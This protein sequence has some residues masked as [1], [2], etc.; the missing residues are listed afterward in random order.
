M[1]EGALVH[2]TGDIE[3][4]LFLN[5][6][7]VFKDLRSQINVLASES[8][9]I[10]Y[11]GDITGYA[12]VN[13]EEPEEGFYNL[14]SKIDVVSS[15][16]SQDVLPGNVSIT[17]QTIIQDL[18]I[19]TDLNESNYT[20]DLY[21]YLDYKKG[22]HESSILSQ[23]NVI[24]GYSA[25]LDGSLYILDQHFKK[26]LM[27]TMYVPAFEMDNLPEISGSTVLPKIPIEGE[28]SGIYGAMSFTEAEYN[29][30]DKAYI[31]GAVW[32]PKSR[33]ISEL[34]SKIKIPWYG[35]I[36]SIDSQIE[37][38][39]GLN[40]YINSRI[41]VNNDQIYDIYGDTS[42]DISSYE[43]I[44]E[45][46]AELPPFVYNDIDGTTTLDKT[47]TFHE[48]GS[49][50]RVVPP[51]D[52][53][54]ECSM[55]VETEFTNLKRD[56]DSMLRI[57]NESNSDLL[58][59]IQVDAAMQ[60][61][62]EILSSVFV[63]NE[64]APSRVGIFVDPLWN[65]EPFVLKNAIST[66]LDRIYSKSYITLLYAG[67]PRANW[68]IKHFANIYRI[69]PDRSIEIP[70][71]FIPGNPMMNRDQMIRFIHS[72]FRFN[73]NDE[74]KTVDKIFLFSDNP[75][76]HN[77]S[78]LAPLLSLA[79]RYDVPITIINSRGEISGVD[80]L[81]FVHQPACPHPNEPY[82]HNHHHHHHPHGWQQNPMSKHRNIFDD[83]D[84]V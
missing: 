62:Y 67:S 11:T 61:P 6:L 21:G 84:I 49:M 82:P 33:H 76:T 55:F 29:D 78:Y 19:S 35:L 40:Y 3:G 16:Y 9:P 4:Y 23:I 30:P 13:K 1:A 68:D 80:S 25:D 39:Y 69:P 27:S 17:S 70:F 24:L 50:I 65:Y 74:Y 75:Y 5:G 52:K 10:T 71:D 46:Q 43:N 53:D 81:G 58:S 44:L 32:I 26:S 57:G 38:V 28:E 37:S 51:Y 2:Y 77:A 12:G 34:H 66:F 14:D 42:L 47:I 63:S 56:I 7:K 18:D 36:Y 41:D 60:A 45:G 72:L 20:G 22:T 79:E 73:P 54:L 83:S 8:P 59:S 48:F 64:L 31:N 15:I